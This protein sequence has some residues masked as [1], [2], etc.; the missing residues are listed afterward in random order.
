M[1]TQNELLESLECVRALSVAASTC[2]RDI[3]ATLDSPDLGAG[4]AERGAAVLAQA[5]RLHASLEQLCGSLRGSARPPA[6]AVLGAAFELYAESLKAMASVLD[7]LASQAEGPELRPALQELLADVLDQWEET[8]DL[9]DTLATPAVE[10]RRSQ[11]I[12]VLGSAVV[13]SEGGVLDDSGQCVDLSVGGLRLQVNQPLTPGQRYE[14]EIR[15]FGAESPALHTT[16]A[17]WCQARPHA[18]GYWAGF[19]PA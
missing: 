4:L 2:L 15:M 14:L 19:E 16:R 11:R 3:A 8:G 12:R 18:G 7:G 13:R 10:G 5:G 1:T 17:V 9:L 6:E